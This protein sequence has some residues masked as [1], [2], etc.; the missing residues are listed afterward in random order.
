MYVN[1][2]RIKRVK[3]LDLD[4][5]K[6]IWDFNAFSLKIKVVICLAFMLFSGIILAVGSTAVLGQNPVGF[7]FRTLGQIFGFVSMLGLI[8]AWYDCCV[9]GD[10][11]NNKERPWR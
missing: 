9:I 4:V 8:F 5:R 3:K 6:G 1:P 10:I 11:A 7:T 2:H